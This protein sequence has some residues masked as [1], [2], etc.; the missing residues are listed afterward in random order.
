M[1]ALFICVLTL[2]Q[3]PRGANLMASRDG[4]TL[5][6]AEFKVTSSITGLSRRL[7]KS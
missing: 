3:D 2:E 4:K 6:F 5:L 1:A 7:W